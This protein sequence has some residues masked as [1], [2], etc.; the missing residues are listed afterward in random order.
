MKIGTIEPTAV[1]KLNELIKDIR[2]AML[3]TV[4]DDGSLRGRPMATQDLPFD[5]DLWFFTAEN[6]H[7]TEEIS[8]E[9]Q[10]AVTYAEPKDQRYI[11]LSGTAV[12][13]RDATKARELWKPI[14]KTWF[15]GGLEDPSLAL[16]HVRVEKAEYWDASSSKMVDLF[17]RAK[18]ALT[19]KHPEEMGEH[20]KLNVRASALSI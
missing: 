9:H 6:A 12:V 5:G 1:S 20:E 13:T 3:T 14:Y 10:V 19:G 11:S 15:P 2:I 7:K 16:L 18:A 17:S 4:A 8:R